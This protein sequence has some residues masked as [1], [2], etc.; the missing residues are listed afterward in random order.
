[1]DMQRER[2]Y[3]YRHI[4][5]YYNKL[6]IKK[7]KEGNYNMFKSAIEMLTMLKNKCMALEA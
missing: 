6:F 3:S 5:A 2:E 1:M 4:S 7:G